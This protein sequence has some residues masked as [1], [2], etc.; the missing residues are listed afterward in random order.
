MSTRALPAL[1]PDCVRHIASFLERLD[2]QCMQLLCHD[3]LRPLYSC[4]VSLVLC[5]LPRALEADA[6]RLMAHFF[7][8][9]SAAAVDGAPHATVARTTSAARPI[10][11]LAVCACIDVDG[12]LR[13]VSRLIARA[14]PTL[15]SLRVNGTVAYDDAYDLFD[16]PFDTFAD[17]LLLRAATFSAP[18]SAGASASPSALESLSLRRCALYPAAVVHLKRLLAAPLAVC[19]LRSLSLRDC[20]TLRSG[21]SDIV[22]SIAC[23]LPHMPHFSHLDLRGSGIQPELLVTPLTELFRVARACRASQRAPRASPR[24]DVL[25]RHQ[26]RSPRGSSRPG[27]RVRAPPQ[28]RALLRLVEASDAVGDPREGGFTIRLDGALC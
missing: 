9:P 24:L 26:P 15:R 22:S 12:P 2:F 10:A 8:P 19:Q 3:L 6:T 25:V 13:E 11:H 1:P 14:A 4:P 27:V 28:Q 7:P 5:G 21:A 16:F 17:A 23:S 20:P 18:T